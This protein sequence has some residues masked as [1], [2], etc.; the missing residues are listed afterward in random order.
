MG[1]AP[2]YFATV[3]NFHATFTTGVTNT[4]GSGAL[5]APTWWNALGVPTVDWMLVKL[6]F[7][8]D[9]ATGVGDLADSIVTVFAR[10][11]GAGNAVRKIRP[12]DLG[13]PAAGSTTVPEFF[14][15]EDFGPAYMFQG[16][17]DLR[18]GISVTPTAGNL[19][20]FGV[21]QAVS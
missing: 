12:I 19:T 14:R 16:S 1:A 4:D 20:V 9:S 7:V 15:E 13:N 5:T 17:T 8:S 2:V 3:R 11:N 6:I 21:A 18:F 10:D